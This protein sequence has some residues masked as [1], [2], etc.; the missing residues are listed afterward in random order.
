MSECNGSDP[1]YE[2]SA[3][4]LLDYRNISAFYVAMF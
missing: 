2:K 1:Y 4:I 3:S